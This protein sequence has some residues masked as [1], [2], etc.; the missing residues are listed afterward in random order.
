M[1]DLNDPALEESAPGSR[2][3][4]FGTGVH[5]TG[6]LISSA[7]AQNAVAGQGYHPTSVITPP[8][9]TGNGMSATDRGRQLVGGGMLP[10]S[11]GSSQSTYQAERPLLS[12]NMNAVT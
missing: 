2:T 11:N 6:G 5:E 8:V 1:A 9:A 10:S 12:P 7:Q 3:M 4:A